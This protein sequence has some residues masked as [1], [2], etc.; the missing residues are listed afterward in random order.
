MPTKKNRIS[1]HIRK[2]KQKLGGSPVKST[3]T[4][5][6]MTSPTIASDVSKMTTKSSFKV[7]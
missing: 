6:I 5:P 1:Q 4:S 2:T 7:V 3:S